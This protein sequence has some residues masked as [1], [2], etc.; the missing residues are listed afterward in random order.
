MHVLS[1]SRWRIPLPPDHAR[2]RDTQAHPSQNDRDP[3]SEPALGRRRGQ[4]RLAHSATMR[5]SDASDRRGLSSF[6][7][8]SATA[9]A[10]NNPCLVM[11]HLRPQCKWLAGASGCRHEPSRRPHHPNCSA[12]VRCQTGQSWQS[13]PTL[14]PL[15]P[16]G[17]VGQPGSLDRS[18]DDPDQDHVGP[19]HPQAYLMVPENS[20]RSSAVACHA[21]GELGFLRPIIGPPRRRANPAAVDAHGGLATASSA[22]P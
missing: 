3:E 8:W 13:G 16:A 20:A 21:D 17:I 11:P 2:L 6:V 4:P 15:R 1:A 5:N 14:R 19:Q 7:L 10:F 12:S 22:Y 9:L 18:P